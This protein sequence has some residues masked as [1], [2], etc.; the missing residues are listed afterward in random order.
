MEQQINIL[1]TTDL[2]GF[3]SNTDQQPALALQNIKQNYPNSLLI[4]S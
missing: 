2:H 4:D 3:I 1:T